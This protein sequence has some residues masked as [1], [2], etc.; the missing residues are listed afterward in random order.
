M[1]LCLQIASAAARAGKSTASMG[2]FDKQPAGVKPTKAGKGQ[3]ALPVATKTGSERSA[4][5]AFAEKLIRER[6]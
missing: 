5:K 2:K 6:G 1:R 4:Q 3:K